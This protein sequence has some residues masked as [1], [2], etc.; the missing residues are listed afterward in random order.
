MRKDGKW[1]EWEVQCAGLKETE[2]RLFTSYKL[3][4][5]RS[6]PEHTHYCAFTGGLVWG[7]G[8]TEHLSSRW[9]RNH[10]PPHQQP[11]FIYGTK[12]YSLTRKSPT[13]NITAVKLCHQ[14][15]HATNMCTMPISYSSIPVLKSRFNFNRSWCTKTILHH[16][17]DCLKLMTN[18][19]EKS[20]DN[21]RFFSDEFCRPVKIGRFHDTR[22]QLVWRT[23]LAEA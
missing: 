22:V 6:V 18:E 12:P 1:C 16:G 23:F 15:H 17:D 8:P 9:P 11:S 5:L 2:Q 19:R 3:V 13:S 4:H 10:S 14:A 21:G 20:A 7:F